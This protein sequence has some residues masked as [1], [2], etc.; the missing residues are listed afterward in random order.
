MFRNHFH[1]KTHRQTKLTE[2]KQKTKREHVWLHGM[3]EEYN[4]NVSG[5]KL[6]EYK[7]VKINVL[8]G[9]GGLTIEG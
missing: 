9:E 5:G 6:V 2:K 1:Q 3:R 4:E 8:H 7:T